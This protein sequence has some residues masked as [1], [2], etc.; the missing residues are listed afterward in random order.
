MIHTGGKSTKTRNFTAWTLPIWDVW[1]QTSHIFTPSELDR[2]KWIR[3]DQD[4]ENV[5]SRYF[6]L[7]GLLLEFHVKFRAAKFPRY[8]SLNSLNW[9][10]WPWNLKILTQLIIPAI[11]LYKNGSFYAIF[12][13]GPILHGFHGTRKP[14]TGRLSHGPSPRWAAWG[15]CSQW[16]SHPRRKRNVSRQ[17]QGIL[18]MFSW[19]ENF[20]MLIHS[21]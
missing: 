19:Y 4:L 16:R 14:L 15:R 7:D 11:A 12:D 6:F 18:E 9:P 1:A 21:S 13:P 10:Y 8:P 3:M 20:W 2:Y 5:F 17:S